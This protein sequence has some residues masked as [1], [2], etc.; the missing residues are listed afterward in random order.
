[1]IEHKTSKCNKEVLNMDGVK[2]HYLLSIILSK[3]QL[4]YIF[5]Y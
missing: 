2:V 4:S 1:M 3:L 5:Q